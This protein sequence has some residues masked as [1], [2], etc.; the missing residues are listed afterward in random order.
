MAVCSGHGL[1][2]GDCWVPPSDGEAVGRGEAGDGLDNIIANNNSSGQSVVTI[3]S[4]RQVL[5]VQRLLRLDQEVDQGHEAA[6]PVN[7]RTCHEQLRQTYNQTAGGTSRGG[8]RTS[9]RSPRQE[10]P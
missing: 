8:W 10:K 1:G 7:R 4:K 3:K 9:A 2:S 5:R 6:T